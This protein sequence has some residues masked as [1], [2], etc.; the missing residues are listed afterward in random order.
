MPISK[1]VSCLFSPHKLNHFLRRI[2]VFDL[3]IMITSTAA[4]LRLFNLY[5]THLVTGT[6]I[7]CTVLLQYHTMCWPVT[8]S[9]SCR[10]VQMNSREEIK[11]RDKPRDKDGEI[12][13]SI[14]WLVEYLDLIH[15]GN[16][17]LEVVFDALCWPWSCF[18]NPDEILQ[19]IISEFESREP[20][21]YSSTSGSSLTC[22]SSRRN[23]GNHYGWDSR[24]ANRWH[25]S[26]KSFVL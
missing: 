5:S 2:S 21:Q 18:N 23:K 12:I 14:F 16:W 26:R 11:R 8:I 20:L 1:C 6:G 19:Q 25:W 9:W 10:R 17:I 7:W 24:Q 15:D 22:K 13:L 3:S 4:P